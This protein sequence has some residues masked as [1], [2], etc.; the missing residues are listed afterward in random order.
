MQRGHYDSIQG[1]INDA[2]HQGSGTDDPVEVYQNCVRTAANGIATIKLILQTDGFADKQEEI[3]FYK[4]EAPRICG[5]YL[6]YNRL[7][8]IEAWRKSRSLLKF[9]DLL[10]DELKKAELVPELHDVCEYYYQ[11]RTDCDEVYFTR[12][13]PSTWSEEG[14]GMFLDP[15]FTAKSYCLSR[16]RAS[17]LLRKW[18]RKELAEIEYQLSGSTGQRKLQW[19]LTVTD[20][21]ELFKGLHEMNCFGNQ[22]FKEV[23]DWVRQ[24]IGIDIKKHDVLLQNI[25]NRKK[26][27]FFMDKVKE[28]FVRYMESKE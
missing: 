11:G 28:V 12:R 13:Q 10:L 22:S 4:E 16:M 27:E 9:R 8:E 18:L 3:W 2:L 7:I 15:D 24:M 23:I 19:N 25:R 20:A 1:R 14:L 26:G 21:V 5:L 6:Y 17:E